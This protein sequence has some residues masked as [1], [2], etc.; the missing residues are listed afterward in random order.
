MNLIAFL[1]TYSTHLFLIYLKCLCVCEY[2]IFVVILK[3]KEL[4]FISIYIQIIIYHF[5]L[6]FPLYDIEMSLYD[7]ITIVVV[8][9]VSILKV[10]NSNALLFN[11]C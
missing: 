9:V 4:Y 6:Y 7:A 2:I 3:Q 10:V 8:V 1:L 11:S 5:L